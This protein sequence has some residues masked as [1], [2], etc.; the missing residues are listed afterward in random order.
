MKVLILAFGTRGDV[1]PFVALA[2]EL[3]VRGHDP[4]LAAPQRFAVLAGEHGVPFSPVDDGPLRLM[5]TA[6]G[7][8]DTM[9]RRAAR[10]G[11]AGPGDAGGVRP[12]VRRRDGDRDHRSGCRC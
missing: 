12:R 10:Q 7:V 8:G 2:R 3:R 11:G 4:V 5:D 9:D 6:G 1:Q